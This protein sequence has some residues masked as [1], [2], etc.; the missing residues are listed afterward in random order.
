[1][2]LRADSN[3]SILLQSRDAVAGFALRPARVHQRAWLCRRRGLSLAIGIGA[4]TAIFTRGE[5]VLLRP[6]PYAHAERLAILWNTSPG[7][8]ITEDWFSTAQYLDIKHGIARFEDVAIAIGANSNLTGDGEPERVGTI[9]VSS[10]LLPMLGASALVMLFAASRRSAGRT[11]KALLLFG[12]WQRR[13]GGDAL[14]SAVADAQ[15]SA[16][17]IVGVLPASS[18]S[19]AKSCRRSVSSTTPRSSSR[20]RSRPT[21]HHS[22]PRGLQHAGQAPYQQDAERSAAA[23]NALTVRL[24]RDH[25]EVYPPNSGLTFSAVPLQEQVVGRVR[26]SIIVLTAAVALVLL[27][28]C[29]N[30]TVLARAT[31]REQEI[32]VRASLGASRRRI[33][34]QLL[35]E[36]LLLALL[37]GVA[38]V[39]LAALGLA[40]IKANGAASVPR[41]DEIGL[42]GAVLAY[43]FAAA[44][45]SGLL[46]GLAPALRLT[47]ASLYA[48]VK[49]G[50]RR[51]VST[52]RVLVTMELAVSLRTAG[53]GGLAAAELCAPAGRAARV[54]SFQ[55]VDG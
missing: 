49:D 24:V 45:L 43:T 32:A 31:A 18:R 5:R 50:A 38:G 36:S 15:R 30:T 54:Q 35:T 46:F 8:G 6:L 25:P 42:D 9:R 17:E 14:S 20:C 22:E 53:R 48:T 7:L 26:R 34:G 55:H 13:Y 37:G 39:A 44:V 29:G 21:P 27:V 23:L 47:R 52:G 40:G 33:V 11:G 10:N 16:Y 28:A 19:R 51:T 4:N 12:T 2:S 1:M 3:R 41:L